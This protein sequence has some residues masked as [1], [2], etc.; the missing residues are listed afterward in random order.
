[1]IYGI[2]FATFDGVQR[3]YV[4][5][6]A[7]PGLRATALGTFH[8]AIGIVALPGGYIAGLLWDKVNP[9]ATFIYGVALSMISLIILLLVKKGIKVES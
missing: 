1:V 5:D 2:A 9:Q 7:P 6:F 4:V 3:A 8:T